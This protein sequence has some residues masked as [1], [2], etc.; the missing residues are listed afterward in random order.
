MERDGVKN[1]NPWN[2][3]PCY[4]CMALGEPVEGTAFRRHGG[5]CTQMDEIIREKENPDLM[6]GLFHAGQEAFKMSGKY[7]EKRFS[8]C[9]E[10][11]PRI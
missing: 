2:D 4:P 8:E 9:G 11:C 10:E 7:N 6:I 5:D 1:R 3:H